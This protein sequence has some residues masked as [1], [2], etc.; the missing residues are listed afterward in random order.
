M[1]SLTLLL[2]M[3]FV[4]DATIV[5]AQ[6]PGECMTKRVAGEAEACRIELI[7]MC[8]EAAT[9][10]KGPS[11][12]SQRAMCLFFIAQT[13]KTLELFNSGVSSLA[14]NI[15]R[16][17]GSP[18]ASN[19]SKTADNIDSAALTAQNGEHAYQAACGDLEAAPTPQNVTN[20]VKAISDHALC[21]LDQVVIRTEAH[22]KTQD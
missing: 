5:E 22:M 13:W 14:D 21:V 18:D 19:L 20:I 6:Q 9:A 3:S 17:L 1:R 15:N 4:L 16:N 11:A 8:G 12:A 2:A 7:A 10:H